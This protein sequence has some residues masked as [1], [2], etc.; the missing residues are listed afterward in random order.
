MGEVFVGRRWLQPEFVVCYILVVVAVWLG[1]TLLN[2][3]LSHPDEFL[4]YVRTK[5]LLETGDFLTVT[6]GGLPSWEKPP[7]QYW[8]GAL[9]LSL[10]FSPVFSLRFLPYLFALLTLGLTALTA[11]HLSPNNRWA[12]P[13]AVILTTLSQLFIKHSRLALLETGL[14]FFILLSVYSLW[15]AQENRNWWFLWGLSCGLGAMQKVPIAWIVSV[16]V[17]LPFLVF[18]RERFKR[19]MVS[20]SF[21]LAALMG[22]ALTLAWPLVQ[23]YRWGGAYWDKVHFETFQRVAQGI[24]EVEGSGMGFQLDRVLFYTYDAA[25]FWV[26]A[27]L[28]VLFAL[29]RKLLKDD[30]KQQGVWLC[31]LV[32]FLVRGQE[33]WDANVR[34]LSQVLFPMICD[35]LDCSAAGELN[36]HGLAQW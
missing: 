23:A 34:L 15:R 1:D 8:G 12:M 17:A 3:G 19:S 26:L 9:L 4:T 2:P 22:L 32:L 29:G 16:I 24:H 5:N 31:W 11:K 10:G 6:V 30:L 35:E 25:V 14:C 27:G 18:R 33:C 36:V 7:L 20:G 28:S 13:F 21:A